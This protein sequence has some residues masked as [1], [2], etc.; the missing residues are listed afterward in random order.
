VIWRFQGAGDRYATGRDRGLTPG[1]LPS[2]PNPRTK[3]T[4]MPQVAARQQHGLPYAHPESGFGATMA[5]L[6]SRHRR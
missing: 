3:T 1:Q 5:L 4:P 2:S 6:F